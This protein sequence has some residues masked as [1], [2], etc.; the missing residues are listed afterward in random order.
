MPTQ[1]IVVGKFP[2]E[3]EA[4]L[5]LMESSPVGGYRGARALAAQMRAWETT[6]AYSAYL[7]TVIRPFG[8]VNPEVAAATATFIAVDEMTSIFSRFGSYLMRGVIIEEAG[9]IE[10]ATMLMQAFSGQIPVMFKNAV[11]KT[12]VQM[13]TD[14]IQLEIARTVVERSLR[15]KGWVRAEAEYQEHQ[16]EARM[17]PG[18][19]QENQSRYGRHKADIRGLQSKLDKALLTRELAL[20]YAV[21]DERL[22]ESIP[23]LEKAIRIMREN[24]NQLL[25]SGHYEQQGWAAARKEAF[26]LT[27]GRVSNKPNAQRGTRQ[28]GGIVSRT[29]HLAIKCHRTAMKAVVITQ[30]NLSRAISRV[31]S[32]AISG[33]APSIADVIFGYQAAVWLLDKAMTPTRQSV[34]YTERER[35]ADTIELKSVN[36]EPKPMGERRGERRQYKNVGVGDQRHWEQVI[37]GVEDEDSGVDGAPNQ[38]SDPIADKATEILNKQPGMDEFK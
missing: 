8:W 4:A 29:Q 5:R 2:P 38:I 25:M 23:K 1:R 7:S 17:L 9:A 30:R 10:L 11:K 14:R 34:T 15:G 13:L 6:E 36:T 16:V 20:E 31:G 35:G 22:N 21:Q 28:A 32:R 37:G 24:Q 27:Y 26:R 18:L 3:V 19:S 12:I 33:K